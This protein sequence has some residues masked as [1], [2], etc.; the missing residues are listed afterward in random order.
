VGKDGVVANLQAWL[1]GWKETKINEYDVSYQEAMCTYQHERYDLKDELRQLEYL[2]LV[3][4]SKDFWVPN[5]N[6]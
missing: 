5:A 3:M 4:I 2:P 6:R 1:R